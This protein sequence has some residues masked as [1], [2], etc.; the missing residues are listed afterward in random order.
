MLADGKAKDK[1]VTKSTMQNNTEGMVRTRS[2]IGSQAT[3]GAGF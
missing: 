2:H 3:I 1:V